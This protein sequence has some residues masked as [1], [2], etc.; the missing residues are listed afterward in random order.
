MNKHFVWSRAGSP[1]WRAMALLVAMWG[2]MAVSANA[3]VP[4]TASNGSD[5][6]RESGDGDWVPPKRST[7]NDIFE[8]WLGTWKC[9]GSAVGPHGTTTKYK[10]T[11]KWTSL[12]GGRWYSAAYARPRQGKVVAYKAN[13]TAGYDRTDKTYLLTSFD[14][15]G[16]WTKLSSVDGAF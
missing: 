15:F 8:K 10:V 14:T 6:G 7:E 9:E 4:S 2:S 13:I 12:L 5:L 11:W 16:G 3:A 1:V